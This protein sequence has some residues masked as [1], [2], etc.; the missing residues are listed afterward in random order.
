MLYYYNEKISKNEDELWNYIADN[1]DYNG[2]EE[3]LVIQE[4]V[5]HTIDSKNELENWCQ[6]WGYDLDSI[7]DEGIS[8]DYLITNGLM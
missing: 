3:L 7:V 5:I 6:E 2:D 4:H 8:I 1:A